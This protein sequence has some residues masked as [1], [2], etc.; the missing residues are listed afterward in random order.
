MKTAKS[1]LRGYYNDEAVTRGLKIDA[2]APKELYQLTDQDFSKGWSFIDYVGKKLG[3]SGQVWLRDTCDAAEDR[4]AFMQ[5][6][7]EA[8]ERLHP[9]DAKTDV[10]SVLDA[11]W[12]EWA[13]T[14]QIQEVDPTR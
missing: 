14:E 6:W 8:T 11:S 7:R 3:K 9:V 13:K 2:I 1:G 5:K 4:A 12:K 10:F